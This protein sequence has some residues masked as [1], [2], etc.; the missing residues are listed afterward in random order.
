MNKI[1]HLLL[2]NITEEDQVIWEGT[3]CRDFYIPSFKALIYASALVAA[4]IG[5]FILE[6]FLG[7]II[8]GGFILTLLLGVIVFAYAGIKNWIDRQLTSYI[9]SEKYIYIIKAY[10]AQQ[11]YKIPF[12]HIEAVDKQSETFGNNTFTSFYI[13]L[14]QE[15]KIDY[16]H[17]SMHYLSLREEPAIEVKKSSHTNA[18]DEV[19]QDWVKQVTV[20]LNINK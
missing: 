16:E 1:H 12:N 13:K 10:I 6:F 14:H 15:H 17:Q 11:I 4:I 2:E 18:L 20:K 3:P 8:P 19:M 5:I 7:D 9:V